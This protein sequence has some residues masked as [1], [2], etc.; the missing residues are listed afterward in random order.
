[1]ILSIVPVVTDELARTVPADVKL[2][3]YHAFNSLEIH[4]FI[5]THPWDRVEVVISKGIKANYIKQVLT[6]CNIVSAKIPEGTALDYEIISR[7][8]EVYPHIAVELKKAY[9]S[10]QDVKAILVREGV[11]FGGEMSKV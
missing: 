7:L 11:T 9:M 8:C 10:K 2:I 6:R 3:D 5:A 1:M 4:P